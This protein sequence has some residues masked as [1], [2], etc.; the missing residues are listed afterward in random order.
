MVNLGKC[1]NRN[2]A[3]GGDLCT[4]PFDVIYFA[5]RGGG[6]IALAAMRTGNDGNILDYE[7]VRTFTITP[8]NVNNSCPGLAAIIAI[9]RLSFRAHLR[10][11][12]R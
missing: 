2:R 9:D 4:I 7:Q 8:G 10:S 6:Q 3:F 5:K 11:D 12:K 1:H